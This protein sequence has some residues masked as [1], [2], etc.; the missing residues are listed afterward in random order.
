M[1]NSAPDH[2]IVDRSEAGIWRVAFS[3]PPINMLAPKTIVELQDLVSAAEANSATKVLIFESADP[4]FFISHFDTAR[5]A[6]MPTELGPSGHAGWVDF[7][8]RLSRSAV[9]SIAKIR[10]RTRGVGNE[11]VLACDMRFASREKALLGNPEVGVGLSPGG[12]A[13]QWL[14]RVVGRSRALEIVLSG[15]DFD[16]EVAERYGWVNRTLSD[17]DLDAFVDQL[18]RRLASYERE[19]LREIKAQ[20]SRMAVPDAEEFESSQQAFWN[21]LGHP[22]AKARRAGLGGRGYGE[23]SDF[24]L[25]FGRYLP[26]LTPRPEAWR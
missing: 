2:L 16:A 24:E 4:D 17:P 19:T 10:G 13:L 25:N 12:G 18:A 23:R 3:N 6:E 8:V 5:S 22:A 7:V 14:P 1:E 21:A 15:D 11:F 26:E 9:I 20:V